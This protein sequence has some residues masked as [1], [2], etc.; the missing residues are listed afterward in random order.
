[1]GRPK[2]DINEDEVYKLASYGCTQEEIAD[3]FGCTHAVI[4]VRFQQAYQ[5]GKSTVRKNVRMWQMRRAQK[6]SDTML[7]HLGKHYCGQTD[8][9]APEQATEDKPATDENGTSLEP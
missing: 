6:G 4:S 5:L 1:V 2:K 8:K 3:F 9:P 7:I